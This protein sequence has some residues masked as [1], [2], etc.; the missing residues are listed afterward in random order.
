MTFWSTYFY[1]IVTG[2]WNVATCLLR[3]FPQISKALIWLR[4][5]RLLFRKITFYIPYGFR[6]KL[7]V[8]IFDNDGVNVNTGRFTGEYL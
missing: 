2:R 1:N 5:V 3:R 8:F 4:C 6:R 7:I